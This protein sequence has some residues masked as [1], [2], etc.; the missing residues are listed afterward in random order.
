MYILFSGLF[1][2]GMSLSGTV[3]VPWTIVENSKEKA[4]KL[5]ELVG[6][7]TKSSQVLVD[8]LRKRPGVKII[9]Q[10]KHFYVSYEFTIL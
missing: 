6:C 2:K 7:E 5:G 10:T 1:H 4:N 3:L 9:Q 8:C